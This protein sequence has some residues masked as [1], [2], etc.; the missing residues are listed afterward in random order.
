MK[1]RLLSLIMIACVA[2][3]MIGCGSKKSADGKVK[4]QFMHS[5]IEEDRQKVIEEIITDFES[6]NP[7]IDVEQVPVD[8]DSYNTKITALGGSGE[9]P[10]VM[11]LGIEF[12]KSTAKNQ[13][14][15]LEAHSEVI[16]GKGEEAFYSRVLDVVKT[17]D[18]KSFT[19]VPMSGWV[20]GIWYDKKAF[21]EKGLKAPETWEDIMAASKAFYDKDNR[22]YGI[23]I[24]TADGLFTEQVFSQFALSNDAN[25]FNE[26]GKVTFNTPEMKEAMEYYKELAKYTMPGS[27]DVTQIKD[28]FLAGNIPMAMYSTYILPA[29]HEMGLSDRIGFAVPNKKTKATFGT[30]T[31]MGIAAGLEEDQRDAAIKFVSHLIDDSVNTKWLHMSPGG[32]QPVLKTVAE[33]EAYLANDVIKSFGNISQDITNSFNEL[34]LFGTVGN[35]NFLSMGDVSSKGIIGKSINNIIIN[36]KDLNSTMQ[37]AQTEIEKTVE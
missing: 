16:S 26:E 31:S 24:A 5:S 25:V 35:K 34:Q 11:E 37:N 18:G 10:A 36:N 14:I 17:E 8:E 22:K 29:V 4:I 27:N 1:K 12:A 32:A 30:V 19:G 3:M 7:N 20:Q 6:K 9:L 2:T 13:F 15:D 21:E 28:A 23:G 33:S